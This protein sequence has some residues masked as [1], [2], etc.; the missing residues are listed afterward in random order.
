MWKSIGAQCPNDSPPVGPTEV[1]I[2]LLTN[3]ASLRMQEAM[4]H[5]PE[6]EGRLKGA[7]AT[8]SERGAIS[9]LR[10]L[11]AV[12]RGAG[13]PRWRR[14]R[15]SR[16]YYRGRSVPGV[17]TS[18]LHCRSAGSQ[19]SRALREGAPPHCTAT[20]THVVVDAFHEWSYLVSP[21]G[22]ACSRSTAASLL[23]SPR[24]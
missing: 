21:A 15:L 22:S 23:E 3:D 13:R 16:R 24:H 5:F 11:K 19:R 17:S 1:C 7:Q 4:A 20:G 9:A 2:A 6:I 18:L 8:T 10:S 12:S 14:F